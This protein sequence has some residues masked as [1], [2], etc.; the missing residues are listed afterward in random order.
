[1]NARA[2]KGA[3]SLAGRVLRLAGLGVDALH[4]GDV[5]RAR[6]VIDDGVE[7]LLYALVLIGR[8]AD[9]GD[10]LAGDGGL[11]DGGADHVGGDFLALQIELHDLVVKVA[12]GL[13]QVGAVLLCL[14]AHVLGDVFDAHILAQVIV[15][16]VGIHVDEVD[17]TAE[18]GFLAD[19]ELYG[20]RVGL[21]PVVHHVDHVVEV[22]AHDVHLVHVDETG[23]VV[24][25]GLAPDGLALGL[26][27][28]LGAQHGDAS[29]QDAQAAL[30]FDSEVHVARGVDDVQPAALPVAGGGGGGDG[31]AALLLLLHPVHGGVALVH[32]AELV[33]DAGVEKDTL[34]RRRLAGVDVGHYADIPGVFK[35]K[36]SGHRLCSLG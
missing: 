2:E 9:D 17:D 7:Q 29:V 12:D 35:G 6:K 19:G 27:A 10:H 31:D 25:V 14:R 4:R 26:D 36:F 20:H 24:V 16:N 33:V 30:D 32:L 3:S 11:A 21:Q 23:D 8:A 18:V 5:Q 34:G 28:A 1:M 22:R 13:Q 15:V